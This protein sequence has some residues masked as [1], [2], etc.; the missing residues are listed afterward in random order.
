MKRIIIIALFITSL[1]FTGCTDKKEVDDLIIATAI[2]LDLNE[3]GSLELSIQI[4]N[5][6]SV[7]NRPMD[8]APVV[9]IAETGRTVQEVLRK[10]STIIPEK[11]FFSHF[12]LLVIGEELA[13]EGILPYVTFFA[14][15]QDALHRFNIAVAR[16][17][18]GKDILK[19]VSVAAHVPSMSAEGKLLEATKYYGIGK[20][21]TNDEVLSDIRS[22]GISLSL[23]SIQ[24]IGDVEKGSD[25]ENRKKTDLEAYTKASTIAVFKKDKLID[26]MDEEESL[27]YNY[28]SGKIKNSYIVVTKGDGT[29]ASVQ[30]M[31]VNSKT[32][33]ILENGKIKFKIS[34][35]FLAEIT[36]DLSG[37]T[38][39]DN[40][41][42]RDILERT[43]YEIR[44]LCEKA[45]QKAQTIKADIFGF[46]RLLYRKKY[47]LW[48]EIKDRFEEEIFP[49]LETEI[50][51]QGKI[52]RV[53]P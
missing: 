15:N 21:Y 18:K 23:G 12:V 42:V 6:H 39:H 16:G 19:I 48:L 33:P 14:I 17:C 37:E 40:A 45:I 9:V 31:K 29:F 36:E 32:K 20:Y 50:V 35:S 24:I 2:A 53:K 1:V 13:R 25:L 47:K 49:E 26:W 41:Y 30:V 51:V 22:E 44:L 46:G 3:E 7:G 27:G 52:T 5:V 11:L 8:A 4:L 10:I 34:I 38:S 43:N 28:I